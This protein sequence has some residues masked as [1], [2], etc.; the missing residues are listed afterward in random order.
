M[1]A[2]LPLILF[3]FCS[4]FGVIGS[5]LACR[6]NKKFIDLIF[7]VM[8]IS[9]IFPDWSHHFISRQDY[10]SQSRGFEV[11]VSDLCM[12]ILISVIFSNWKKFRVKSFPPLVIPSLFFLFFSVVAWLLA[13]YSLSNPLFGVSS[14]EDEPYPVFQTKLYPLFEMFQLVKSFVF[15]SIC[16][17]FFKDRKFVNYFL[18]FS[19]IVIYFFGVQ[20]LINRY[21]FGEY[22]VTVLYFVTDFNVIIAMLGSLI[23]PFVFLSKSVL[24]KILF[25]FGVALIYVMLVLS[26]SRSGILSLSA[27]I[28]FS[29]VLCLMRSFNIKN[30]L[31]VAFMSFCVLLIIMK[32][33]NT[34]YERFFITDATSEEFR[35]RAIYENIALT[36][37]GDN[38]LGI[39]MGN[40]SAYYQHFYSK[41]LGY[42][43]DVMV[44]NIWYLTLVE[45]GVLGVIAFICYW[46]RVLQISVIT[47][48]RSFFR[49]DLYT[50]GIILGCICALAN[51]Q[52][53]S[54]FHFTYRI[55][56]ILYYGQAL[57]AIIVTQYLL[58]RQQIRERK[59]LQAMALQK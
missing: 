58:D 16:L 55:L 1:T 23:F 50:F 21:V 30:L 59:K 9:M 27:T 31:T 26:V 20:S 18:I 17:A 12:L 45:V 2:F 56:P 5:I 24:K 15:Y 29:T 46:L 41:M 43:D 36:I 14:F 49:G 7:W 32:G 4:I 25:G 47:L 35:V 13:D 8:L 3:W 22:R 34:M 19:L 40:Y 39:G 28:M 33:Y 48:W 52:F 57:I 6:V 53:R 10:R 38:I 44:H 42:S 37:F 11:H 54:M 51:F